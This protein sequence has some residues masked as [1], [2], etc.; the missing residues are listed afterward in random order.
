MKVL[1]TGANGFIGKNLVNTLK[2]IPNIEILEFTRENTIDQLDNYVSNCDFIFQLVG[3]NRSEKKEDF[4]IGNRDFN[5]T[6]I[7]LLK[8]HKSKAP[9]VL[10]SSVHA[11]QD[12]DYGLSKRQGEMV[13]EEFS[14]E[15]DSQVIIYRLKNLFGKWS[16]PNYN[17]VVATWCYKIANNIEINVNNPNTELELCYIDDVVNEFINALMNNPTIVDGFGSVRESHTITLQALS[18]LIYSF[19]SSRDTLQGV[20]TG[21]VFINKLYATYLSYLK[22]DD[23]SYFLK[24]NIDERGSFTEFLKTNDYGQVSVNIIKPGIVKGNHWHHTKNEKFLVVSGNGV[25]RFRN[26]Y[27]DKIIE[28]FIS[29]EKLEVLDIPTGYTHNIENLGTSDMVTI[30][31]ASELFDSEKPDTHFLEV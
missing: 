11:L 13:L 24:M 14:K 26:V 2:N 9:I 29:S 5:E 3:I 10:T 18:D 12:S 1:V 25:I 21:D 30:M 7:S 4:F 23:F 6:L 28:Y 8:K 22:E 17:S 19:K 15:N 20:K 31:W 16:R 27:S